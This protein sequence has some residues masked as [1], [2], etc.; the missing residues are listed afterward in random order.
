MTETNIYPLPKLRSLPAS[1]PLEIAIR[2]ELVEGAPVFKA[3][4]LIQDRIEDLLN[5]Q[6]DSRLR[7]E[8]EMELDRYEEIDDY[9]GFVN[10]VVRNLLQSEKHGA[11]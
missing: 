9:L 3:S 6:R 11:G 8:E 4:Q 7:P 5:K 2:I 1:L 10:R